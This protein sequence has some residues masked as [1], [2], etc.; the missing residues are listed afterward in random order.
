M[1]DVSVGRAGEVPTGAAGGPLQ[2]GGAPAPA[3]GAGVDRS[4]ATTAPLRTLLVEDFRQHSSSL[5]HPGLHALWVHRIGHWGLSQPPPVRRAVKVAHRLVNRLLIQNLYGTEIAD[6]AFIGRR[7]SIGHHQAVQIPAFSV[8]GDGSTLR[9]NV[10]LGFTSGDA[11][12]EAV[13][14]IGRDVE[15]GAGATLLGP[16]AV[17]DGAKIGPHALVTVDVPAGATA[18]SPPARILKPQPATGA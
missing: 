17:G 11:P 10:T 14:R 9:H 13:P 4:A 1:A 2:D 15:V 6:E 5:V 8:I 3:P 18:F 16:I 12:R 7:V